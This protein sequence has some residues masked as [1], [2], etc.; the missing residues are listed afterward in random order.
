MINNGTTPREWKKA[1]VVP[2]HKGGDRSAEVK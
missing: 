1:M 2:I